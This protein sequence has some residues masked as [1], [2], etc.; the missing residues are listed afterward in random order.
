MIELKDLEKFV[1][2]GWTVKKYGIEYCVYARGHEFPDHTFLSLDAVIDFLV[3]A[4]K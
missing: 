4:T 3:E 1:Y 2:K